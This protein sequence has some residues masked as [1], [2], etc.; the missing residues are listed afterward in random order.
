MNLSEAGKRFTIL[1]DSGNIYHLDLPEGKF[2]VLVAGADL[3]T[4]GFDFNDDNVAAKSHRI[5]EL[6]HYGNNIRGK[7]WT[8]RA[9]IDFYFVFDKKDLELVEKEAYSYPQVK[10]GGKTY[11]LSVTG[12]TDGKT[13]TDTV[14]SVAHIGIG[15]TK[16]SLKH[17]AKYAINP[18]D[19]SIM[20]KRID[21]PGLSENGQ[22]SFFALVA[23]HKA[24][25]ALKQG[26]QI[27]LGHGCNYEGTKGPFIVSCINRRKRTVLA[28]LPVC[29]TSRVRMKY[30]QVDWTQTA[31]ANGIELMNIEMVNHIGGIV[32]PAY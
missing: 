6:K 29:Y 4:A 9:G 10:I 25:K 5:F 31:A 13:W 1:S 17:L 3:G 12:G 15:H 28:D 11:T 18:F 2:I 14:R 8:R 26:D 20:G 7:Y 27:F 21:I 24:R 30:N 22:E 16:A 23:E 19:S 32:E